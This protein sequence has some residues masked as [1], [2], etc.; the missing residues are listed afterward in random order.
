MSCLIVRYKLGQLQKCRR[1]HTPSNLLPFGAVVDHPSLQKKCSPIHKRNSMSAS[2]YVIVQRPY[3]VL[4]RA[5]FRTGLRT[6]STVLVRRN[7]DRT[8]ITVR[9]RLFGSYCSMLSPRITS[10]LH[11][12]TWHYAEQLHCAYAC[13]IVYGACVHHAL[14][15]WATSVL[16]NVFGASLSEPHTNGT[17]A[18]CIVAIAGWHAPHLATTRKD[19][20]MPATTVLSCAATRIH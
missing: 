1:F 7:Y 3:Y 19:T 14:Y 11:T 2:T 15:K 16:S 12:Y 5:T 13:M 8:T 9:E 6:K 4:F 10:H 20:D 18:A 17:S